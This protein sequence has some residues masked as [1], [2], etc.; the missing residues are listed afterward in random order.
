MRFK[1][2]A[3]VHYPISKAV[4]GSHTIA[5]TFQNLDLIVETF[6]AAIG[7]SIF[8]G[9]QNLFAPVPKSSDAGVEFWQSHLFGIFDPV[10]E[11][12]SLDRVTFM[13]A[14]SVKCFLELVGLS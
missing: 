6:C 12:F 10:I 5:H 1:L 11:S 14:N 4:K 8:E 13:L 9:I 3:N 2:R 7:V